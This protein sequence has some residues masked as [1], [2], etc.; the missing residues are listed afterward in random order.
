MR[1]QIGEFLLVAEPFF[2]E[3]GDDRPN[4]LLGQQRAQSRVGSQEI[5]RHR[6]EDMVFDRREPRLDPIAPPLPAMVEVE[7][8]AVIDQ[9]ELVV[10]EEQ[11]G[12]A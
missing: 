10:P 6:Q 3:I 9:P 8:R 2:G 4:D 11:V 1:R 7:R 5:G 12:I